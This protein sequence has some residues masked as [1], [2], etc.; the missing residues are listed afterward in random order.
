MPTAADTPHHGAEEDVVF[1]S[2]ELDLVFVNNFE[3][4]ID[5]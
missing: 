5:H 2:A 4:T 3:D 1:Q